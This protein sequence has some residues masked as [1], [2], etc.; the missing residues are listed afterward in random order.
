MKQTGVSGARETIIDVMAGDREL[1]TFAGVTQ[2]LG[3]DVNALRRNVKADQI[4][5][6]ATRPQGSDTRCVG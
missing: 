4:P 5:H 2:R 6:R 1:L 3:V